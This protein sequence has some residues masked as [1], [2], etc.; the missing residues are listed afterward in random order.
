VKVR[1]LRPYPG[2][3]AS[4]ATAINDLG[5]AVG[6]SGLCDQAVG[7]YSALRAV[8]WDKNGKADTIPTLGGVTWHTPMDINDQGD[9]VGFSNPPGAPDPGD[10]IAHAFLWIDGAPSAKD[11]RVLP[12]DLFSQAMAVNS[13]R[14][15]VGVSFG[16]SEGPRAFL[17]QNEVLMDLNDLVDIGAD[18]LQSA[19]DINDAGQ[20]TGRV[21]DA[22]TG[23]VMMFVAT[24]IGATP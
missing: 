23:N 8:R 19:Q 12:G 17:W 5:V 24:P 9:I 1:P 18:V 15:V 13:L 22:A 2:D 20:I 21:R 3:S 7:R 10:F 16:G 6:I 11:L 4:A 14:Q